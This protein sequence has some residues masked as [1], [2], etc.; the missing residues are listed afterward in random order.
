MKIQDYAGAKKQFVE[1]VILISHTNTKSAKITKTRKRRP[2]YVKKKASPKTCE[3]QGIY[4]GLNPSLSFTIKTEFYCYSCHVRD[5]RVT[6]S[7]KERIK[8]FLKAFKQI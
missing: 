8:M 1:T 7:V 3:H 4:L 5:K 6:A 2:L